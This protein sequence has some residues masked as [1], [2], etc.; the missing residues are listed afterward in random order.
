MIGRAGTGSPEAGIVKL[1]LIPVLMFTP[2]GRGRDKTPRGP[3]QT[4]EF[5]LWCWRL[6]DR[7]TYPRATL[8]F[9]FFFSP[10]RLSFNLTSSF[11]DASNFSVT[12]AAPL[13]SRLPK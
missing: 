11:S 9:G 6:P 5:G 12:L 4:R 10:P 1:A 13:R 3:A 8:C 2:C 7:I